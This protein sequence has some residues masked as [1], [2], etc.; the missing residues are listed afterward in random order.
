VPGFDRPFP[1]ALRDGLQ[2]I[3]WS[4]LQWRVLVTATASGERVAVAQQ[5]EMR[6]EIAIHSA[7]R[8][9]LPLMG[10]LP[11]LVLLMRHVVRRALEPVSRLAAHVDTHPAD[12]AAVL[13]DVDVPREIQPFVHSIRRLL[14]ELTD[15]LALQ[16]RFVANAAH[17]LRSPIAALRLQASNVDSVVTDPQARER[18]GELLEGILR[19][20]RLL[21]QLL[22]MARSQ[23]GSPGEL[24]A[25]PLADVARQVLA[26]HMAGAVAKGIDLGADRCEAGLCILA[27]E[28]DVATLLRN[29]IGNA[30]THCPARSV[31]T[32]SLHAEGDE[33]V[34]ALE[35]DGP[36]IPPAHVERVFEPFYRG[37]AT[38]QP[39]SGLGLSIVTAIGQRLGGRA[40]LSPG[41]RG[42]GLR[43]EY[44]QRRAD[45]GA[46]S[47][48]AA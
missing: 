46:S 4:D 26:E 11:V 15:T 44:R 39:G 22:A 19:I 21:E 2:T 5:T 47:T 36:G 40:T 27:T 42:Q 31:V 33:A 8:T 37:D 28:L 12:H 6:D 45:G 25:V 7:L 20:E 48:S 3:A 1:T 23:S 41:P 34:I 29:V 13:P 10:L 16:R 9:V 30:V 35:D 18:L 43:F 38:G 17:E 24:K 32:L 14:G